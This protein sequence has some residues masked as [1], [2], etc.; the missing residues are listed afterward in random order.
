MNLRSWLEQGPFTLSLTSGFFGFYSHLGF[1]KALL[2]EGFMPQKFRGC[3]AGAIVSAALASGIKVHELENILTSLKR[4]DFWDPAIG[5]GLLR[6][7]KFFALLKKQMKEHFDHLEKPLEVSVFDLKSLKT[8]TLKSGHLP[9]AIWASCAVPIM[10][11]PVKIDGRLYYDGG[12][13]DPL[14]IHGIEPEERILIHDISNKNIW[15]QP[16]KISHLKNARFVRMSKI[17]TCG[18]HKL[19]E[20]AK[21]IQTAYTEIKKLLSTT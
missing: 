19:N 7:E 21:I 13:F 14:A 10:F 9:H 2:E 18:P 12:I 17:P 11:Y 3:S 15:G 5:P 8:L 6:G 20:G 16:Q 1:T 4:S